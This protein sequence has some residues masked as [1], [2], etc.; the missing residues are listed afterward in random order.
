MPQIIVSRDE[1]QQRVN[2]GAHLVEVL[3]AKGIRPGAP[4]ARDQH[5]FGKTQREDDCE[6]WIRKTPR[7]FIAMITS[8]TWL[9][10]PR[11]GSRV[12]A[13]KKFFIINREKPIGWRMDCPRSE[14]IESR[15]L[16]G[17]WTICNANCRHADSTNLLGRPARERS[18]A[19]TLSAR[20]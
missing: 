10:E 5:S 13:S 16:S 2:D 1:L 7:S 17:S 14:R 8:E 15:K 4:A 6:P 19:A 11:R 9:P 3:P 12:L 20:W 18:S